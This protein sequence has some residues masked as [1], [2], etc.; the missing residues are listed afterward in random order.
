MS[1]LARAA[2]EASTTSSSVLDDSILS[3]IVNF[4]QQFHVQSDFYR[5]KTTHRLRKIQTWCE[6]AFTLFYDQTT[7]K[8]AWE[9]FLLGSLK[10][11]KIKKSVNLP[12][13][14]LERF[15]SLILLREYSVRQVF[16]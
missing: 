15:L 2:D 14:F 1:R 7:A 4:P 6:K 3:H 5:I 11:I 12:E 13:F 9:T 10:T 16:H 8:L